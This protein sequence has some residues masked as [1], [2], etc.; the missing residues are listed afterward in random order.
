MVSYKADLSKFIGRMVRIK[1]VD[2]AAKDWGLISVDSF[3][4]YYES[5][6]NLPKEAIL[7]K[8]IKPSQ[9]QLVNGGFETGDLTGWTTSWDTPELQIGHITS[10]E[11][12]WAEK[13]P[14]NKVGQ[15]LFT[16]IADEFN[17][18]YL[19]SSEFTLAGSGWITFLLG[20]GRDSNLCYISV[21]DAE[22]EEELAR[23]G[24]SEFN[25]LGTSLINQGSNLANMVLYQAD[26]SA[27][28]GRRLKFKIVDNATKDWGLIC[29][30]DF[31]TYY[32]SENDLPSS[33]ISAKNILLNDTETEQINK[34][35]L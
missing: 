20:G 23:Y 26:L 29:V 19:L 33:A 12:W 30:D 27:Y 1:V 24:N 25:D 28:I 4:T 7:A 18:G 2:N 22:S 3:I 13:L 6:D 16:G 15:Y 14:Y 34:H 11:T 17:T 9:Y 21:I 10:E 5:L 31:V 8:D 32:A 35:I